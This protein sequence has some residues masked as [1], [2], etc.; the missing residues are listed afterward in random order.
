MRCALI[1]LMA[2]MAMAAAPPVSGPVRLTA[3]QDRE[4]AV[5]MVKQ[6]QAEEKGR[7]EEAVRLARE[8]ATLRARWQGPRHWETTDAN[9]TAEKW[10]RLTMVAEKDRGQVLR[11]VLVNREEVRLINQGNYKEALDKVRE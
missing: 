3:E 10:Q 5:L 4:I 1:G 7:F 8:I 2:S 11:A 6:S 9:F